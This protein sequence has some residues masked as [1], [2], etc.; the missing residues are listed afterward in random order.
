MKSAL[1]GLL[2]L[3]TIAVSLVTILINHRIMLFGE[4]VFAINRLA[5][6]AY[7]LTWIMML[8]YSLA[9]DG[10]HSGFICLY[11][12]ASLA[13]AALCVITITG[14]TRLLEYAAYALLFLLSP[15]FGLRYAGMSDFAWSMIMTAACACYAFAALIA[16]Y[17]RPGA[18]A[19]GDAAI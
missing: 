9:N 14:I 4:A 13:G 1:G 19:P 3:L 12:F 16:T 11:W 2:T 6:G 17:K 8:A 18:R 7:M 5:S 15:F 10:E